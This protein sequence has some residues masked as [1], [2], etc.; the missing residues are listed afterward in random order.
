MLLFWALLLLQAAGG[1]SEANKRRLAEHTPPQA[2]VALLRDK[3]VPELFNVSELVHALVQQQSLRVITVSATDLADPAVV[4]PTRFRVLVVPNAPAL[5]PSSLGNYQAYAMGGGSLVLLGGK[6]RIVPVRWGD[7][8]AH[9]N[10]MEDY[11][12]L[13]MPDIVAV[14]TVPNPIVPAGRFSLNNGSWSGLSAVGWAVPRR[15]RV[16]PVLVA[17]KSYSR[18]AGWAATLVENYGGW[19]SQCQPQ[20]LAR[21]CF[22]GSSFFVFGITT[23]SFYDAPAFRAMIGPAIAR[24]AA[25]RMRTPAEPPPPLP[26]H[27][28]RVPMRPLVIGGA[29]NRTLVVEGTGTA[30]HVVGVNYAQWFWASPLVENAATPTLIE[31]DV[32]KVAGLGFNTVR[33]ACCWG[34]L[35][36]LPNSSA[37]TTVVMD[38]LA[39]HRL[40]VLFTLPVCT[41]E[42][43]CGDYT[44]QTL[45]ALLPRHRDAVSFVDVRN[46]VVA[47]SLA[48]FVC[49]NGSTLAQSVGGWDAAVWQRFRIWSNVSR[50]FDNFRFVQHRLD[51]GLPREF[52]G[53]FWATNRMYA[54]YLSWLIPKVRQALPKA[55]VCCGTFDEL[56][57][58]PAA[59]MAD[60]ACHHSYP[61]VAGVAGQ[62]TCP[63]G[64]GGCLTNSCGYLGSVPLREI[65]AL[66]GSL[67]VI[68]RVFAENDAVRP[69]VH[70]ETGISDGLKL[71]ATR[72]VDLHSAS[73]WEVILYLSPIAKGF[74]G[75]IRWTINDF[76]AYASTA[77]NITPPLASITVTRDQ[78]MGL[79]AYDGTLRGSPKP[80]AHAL[81]FIAR[82]VSEVGPK[83]WGPHGTLQIRNASTPIHAAYTY[84]APG[85]LFVG[86]TQHESTTLQFEAHAPASNV[87]IRY[88]C[89]EIRVLASADTQARLAVGRLSPLLVNASVCGRRGALRWDGSWLEVQL[90]EGEELELKSACRP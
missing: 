84:H 31:A 20:K 43:K 34:P 45:S 41:S 24:L 56:E 17:R 86:D 14:D 54:T 68:D 83:I 40:R 50:D 64:G 61:T 44:T 74:G 2:T 5:P 12:P 78:R 59:S 77:S 16:T 55:L 62:C 1:F 38:A 30:F 4:A 70:G 80:V 37:L 76:E 87:F 88:N 67:E 49:A 3:T 51:V 69:I 28:G 65:V 25:H 7:P 47:E 11:A 33:L 66:P 42:Q 81:A 53:I 46:E 52:Q 85:A 73:V 32:E 13:R 57:L 72:Y 19:G 82:W 60:F 10:V 48:A 29:D 79:Y 18:P 39:A 6:P 58:L 27:P 89:S 22:V 75:T 63:N 35:G 23:P 8:A 36:F 71:D 26:L 90:L 21:G 15:S 9:I